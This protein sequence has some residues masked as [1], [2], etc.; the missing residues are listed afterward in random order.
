MVK[1]FLHLATMGE[2][3]RIGSEL[4]DS[5][6]SSGLLL[7]CD[8]L[9]ICIVGDGDFI[10]VSSEK[11]K[12]HK[13]G[14]IDEYEF[15]TLQLI[16]DTITDGDKILYINGLG[17]TNDSIF[18]QSW[19]KYLTYFNIVKYNHCTKALDNGYD[20]CGVD[21]RTNPLQHYSGNF[22]WANSSYLKTLPKIQ[23][24]NKPNSPRVLTLRHNAEMYIGMNPNVKP[25]ILHQSNI[26]QYERHLFTYDK[27]N[28]VDNIS[29]DDI[30]KNI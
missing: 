10:Y 8:E 28:Y 22:W 12:K 1:I 20:T 14:R 6:K 7:A 19:R 16:E 15:P 3:Q 25:R 4:M 5:I 13:L 26:S 9:N 18:K 2:Y 30:V 29:N 27:E 17:V 11:I 23:T 21:W 24:L